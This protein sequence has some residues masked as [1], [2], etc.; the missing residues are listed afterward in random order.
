MD[1]P[2]RAR[3]CDTI[4]ATFRNLR[5]P[6]CERT[7]RL[8]CECARLRPS[9]W[10]D[11]LRHRTGP[12]LDGRSASSGRGCCR[13]WRRHWPGRHSAGWSRVQRRGGRGGSWH[14]RAIAR[15]GWPHQGAPD[16]SR[17]IASAVSR[18]ALRC[19]RDR[20]TAL[21][22]P[23]WPAILAETHRVL[24]VGGSLLHEWGNG[25]IDEEWVQIREE[26]RRLFEQA[27]V[28]MPFHP[29][30]RSETEVD[31]QLEDLGLHR[32]GE[33]E[34]GPGPAITLRQFLRRVVDGEL[35]YIWDVPEPVRAECLPR[36]QRW[37]EERFDLERLMPMPREVRWTIYRKRGAR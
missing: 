15:E 16:T 19:C 33:V 12:S 21:S 2:M 1:C 9:T 31:E 5:K 13:H 26:A 29:G 7:R 6:D 10:R 17:R 22:D 28:P 36:L 18:W 4:W 11:H 8:L 24:A 23:D 3:A 35:S 34:M 20:S 25:Q 30:V 37:C 27:G 32:D 14:A